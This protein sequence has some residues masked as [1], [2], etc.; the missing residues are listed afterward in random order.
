MTVL[1]LNP[2][3]EVNHVRMLRK[4]SIY[5]HPVENVLACKDLCEDKIK[6][7]ETRIITSFHFILYK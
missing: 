2:A 5:F 4:T 1:S 7:S 6:I 3:P